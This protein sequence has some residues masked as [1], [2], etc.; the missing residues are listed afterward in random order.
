MNGNNVDKYY[1]IQRLNT[2]ITKYLKKIISADILGN[3]NSGLDNEIQLID[4]ESHITD[5]A[6][7][8][9]NPLT[10]KNAVRLST[11]YCQY[12]WFISDIA[13]EIL[14]RTIIERACYEANISMNVFRELTKEFK[15]LPL[16]LLK[17][18]ISKYKAATEQ[19]DT[20]TTEQFIAYYESV[21]EILSDDFWERMRKE[22]VLAISLKDGNTPIDIASIKEFDMNSKYHERVNS[23]YCYGIAFILLHELS[24]H[25]LGHV[26]KNDV[27]GD[28]ENAD[29]CAFWSIFNDIT[30]E[31]RFSANLSILFVFFSFMQL[32]P[33]LSEDGIHKRDDQRLFSIYDLIKHENSKYTVA[34]ISLLNFWAK[35]NNIKGYPI[36]L[37]NEEESINKIKTFFLEH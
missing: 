30:G 12:F 8:G 5:V 19:F 26:G 15:K 24:H 3:I 1:P 18:E 6:S 23:I 27:W 21:S 36:D 31:Q 11:A 2:N 16:S 22:Y 9:T 34:I 14:D 33:N 35:T 25:A 20:Y 7:I 4:Q 28:E 32:E 10:N 29:M 13:L 17:S 37:P